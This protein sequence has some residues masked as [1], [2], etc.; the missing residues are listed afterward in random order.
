MNINKPSGA[1]EPAVR[2]DQLPRRKPAKITAVDWQSL[3]A[4][5]RQR[6]Q[7]FG[8]DE[9]VAIELMHSGP[10]GGDPLALR[11]G[12]MVV[13]VR[14]AQAAAIKVKVNEAS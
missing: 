7:E 9:G 1:N 14:R 3:D 12:R 6:L 11:I 10:M 8:V 13:A 5:A 4:A 2:A